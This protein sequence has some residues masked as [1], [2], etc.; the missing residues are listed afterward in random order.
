MKTLKDKRGISLIV[1]VITIIL[2]II[3]AGAIILSLNASGVIE[4]AHKAVDSFNEGAEKERLQVILSSAY[5]SNMLTESGIKEAV[6]REFG[7][8][9]S[10]VK[11]FD[12]GAITILIEN[13][14]R[15]FYVDSKGQ[16]SVTTISKVQDAE[17]LSGTGTEVNPYKINSIEDL[18]EFSE[19]I[20]T[21][22]TS[23]VELS[24]D[25]DFRSFGSYRE[26]NEELMDSLTSGEGFSPINGYNGIF[27]GKNHTIS[28]LFIDRNND[29]VALFTVA[30]TKINIKNLTLRGK[31]KGNNIVA[32]ILAGAAQWGSEYIVISNCNTY[33]DVTGNDN[34]CGIVSE[35]GSISC[36][37]CNNYGT[38]IGRDN[39]AGITK[40]YANISNCNNYGIIKGRDN[41]GGIT[42]N[43][44]NVTGCNNYGNI[45]GTGIQI[46]GISGGGTNIYNC[47]NFGK[48]EGTECVGGIQGFS[49][50]V[51]K[52]QRCY[53][54]GQVKGTKYVGGIEGKAW[55]G[56]NISCAYNTKSIVGNESVGGIVGWI[57][58]SALCSNCYSV[59]EV[60]GTKYIGGIAGSVSSIDR[61]SNTYYLNTL[62]CNKA[63][64]NTGDVDGKGQSISSSDLKGTSIIATL[65]ASHGHDDVDYTDNCWK[66]DTNNENNG[67]P[68]FK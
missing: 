52:I 50:N 10:K 24:R 49:Y 5:K 58:D 35:I 59:G 42:A 33:V 65:N 4:R 28:N 46:G 23:Y 9:N 63:F 26:I 32:G 53:N 12:D 55:R 6:D 7:I 45:E 40:S 11:M 27:D 64:G 3:I 30:G 18:V 61:M 16:I 41:C 2:I 17:G 22:K 51:G 15:E 36:L 66:L 20:N 14:K 31:V 62:T 37:N 39:C 47:A 57:D 1:L 67:Y 48:V 13:S 21:Y 56:A 54:M 68:I 60:Q 29:K 25:L 38:I 44:G 43:V 19:N 34:V 8:N